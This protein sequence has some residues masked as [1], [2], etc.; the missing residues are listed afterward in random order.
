MTTDVEDPRRLRVMTWNIWWRFG[1]QWRDRQPRIL[2]TIEATG[3]DVVSLQ[4]VWGTG[5]TTQAHEYAA[6]LGWHA[7]FAGPAYPPAPADGE[8]DWEGVEVGI[9]LVSRW[10]IAATEVVTLQARHRPYD[11]VALLATLEHPAGPLT[12]V[13]GCLEYEPE[14]ND[15]RIAQAERLVE[16][17]TDPRLDGPNPV[18]V[19]GDLN[20][21]PESPVLR[22]LHDRL[23]DAWAAGDGDPAAVSLPSSHPS[24]PV[25][26]AELI[27]QRIDHIFYRPGRARSAVTVGSAELAGAA[28]EGIFPSD[29]RAVVCDL[30]WHDTP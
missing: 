28:I 11:P 15:D 3:A 29:P 10:P 14:Y 26:A 27:D 23:V 8:A 12:V 30:S 13:V 16:L 6:R 1:P 4:E 5:E 17:A 2:R 24:A 7:A 21:A 18:L 22:P 9:G 19:T 20:A 25:E